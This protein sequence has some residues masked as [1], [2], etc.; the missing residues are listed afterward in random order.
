MISVDTKK[1]ELVGNF[2]N[3]GREWQPKGTPEQVLV[4]DFPDDATAKAIPYGVYDMA[5]QWQHDLLH[6]PGDNIAQ[7][8][9]GVSLVDDRRAY[10]E[11][12]PI[13]WATKDK[14][15]TAFLLA[16]GTED[17]TVEAKTQ[18]EAFLLALKQAGFFAR[19]CV[20]QGAPH[21]WSNEP[22]DEPGSFSGFLAPRALRFFQEK[23]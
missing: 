2:R 6:R 20:L 12:L 5:A 7:K 14:A 4:H 18:S 11:S 22:M 19:P 21:F 23:L 16:W 9:L 17:D 1:K 10:F 15:Q 13:S 8:F 3:A